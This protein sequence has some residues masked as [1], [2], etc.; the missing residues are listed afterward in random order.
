MGGG[1]VRPIYYNITW[2]VGGSSETP[3]LYYVIYEQPL[4]GRGHYLRLTLASLYLISPPDVSSSVSG[5][6]RNKLPK[7]KLLFQISGANILCMELSQEI[8][9]PDGANV[10]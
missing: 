8:S 1:G 6:P 2:G 7:H 4:K 5:D 9:S 3:K 10:L